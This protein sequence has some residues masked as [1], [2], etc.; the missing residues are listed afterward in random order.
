MDLGEPGEV[1]G[2]DIP[3]VAFID[4]AIGDQSLF[5]EFTQPRR[6]LGVEFGIEGGHEVPFRRDRR[7]D[8]TS[9]GPVGPSLDL[10]VGLGV[11]R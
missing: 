11:R 1:G 7:T 4:S 10:L 2:A 5:D 6:G 9:A 8:Q 3:E